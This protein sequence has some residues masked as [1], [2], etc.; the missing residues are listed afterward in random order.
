MVTRGRKDSAHLKTESHIIVLKRGSAGFGFNIL[1]G[2]DKPCFPG[3]SGIYVAKIRENEAAALDGRLKEGDKVL[4]AGGVSL[5]N[6]QHEEAADVFR[7]VTNNELVLQIERQ[8]GCEHD[9]EA[10]S[11]VEWKPPHLWQHSV[12]KPKK[13]RHSSRTFNNGRLPWIVLATSLMTIVI[14]MGALKLTAVKK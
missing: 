11:T 10:R 3:N 14:V 1:G 4:E 7:N 5:V 8:V 13:K 6:I 9:N 2:V 12:K